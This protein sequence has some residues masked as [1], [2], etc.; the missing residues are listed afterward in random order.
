MALSFSVL[1]D[2]SVQFDVDRTNDPGVPATRLTLTG[3]NGD[4]TPTLLPSTT[5]AGL[6]ATVLATLKPGVYSMAVSGGI[7][8]PG[9]YVNK[10]AS[11][12][13]KVSV[14]PE[15][16]SWV[17]MAI[18]LGALGALRRRSKMH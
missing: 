18:G 3:P 5:G 8:N 7:S 11:G 1:S 4:F 17:M 9:A 16:S 2:T 15:A 10:Y 12:S 14:V 6:R 13:I